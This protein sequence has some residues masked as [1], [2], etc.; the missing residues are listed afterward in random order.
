MRKLILISS[1]F[2]IILGF[3]LFRPQITRA[4]T[5]VTPSDLVALI[6]DWRVDRYGLPPLIE[7][8]ILMGTA[9]YTA[10]FM[11]DN[12][13]LDHMANLGY[14]GVAARVAAA[15]YNN[16][17]LTCA[18]EN[19]ENSFRSLSEIAN[20]WEDEQHQ[21]PASKEQFQRI[22]AGVAVDSSGVPWYIVHAACASSSSSSG[23]ITPSSTGFT[24]TS[25]PD[26]SIHPMITTTPQEDGSVYHVVESGQT[27]WAIAVAYNT[28]IET[29]K[30][31][32]TLS[33][34][35]VWTGMKLL[36]MHAPTPTVSPTVTI[37]PIPPTRTPTHPTTPKPSTSALVTGSPSMIPPGT[38]EDSFASRRTVGLLIIIF[39][40]IGLLAVM[41]FSFLRHPV[42]TS[43]S[44][45]KDR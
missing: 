25:T 33:S 8:S 18:T 5:S 27:L 12:H 9:Q 16:G 3:Y 20:G 36:I 19:W 43:N 4:S 21:Y 38:V 24:Q 28:H 32:N 37:T 23:S 6:N 13:L 11:A 34:D 1:T 7:D 17:V 42:K 44:A 41:A 31:L 45:K 35:T 40:G 15:G 29:L 2:C 14:D 10:Q 39:S 26:N 22:G 30:E